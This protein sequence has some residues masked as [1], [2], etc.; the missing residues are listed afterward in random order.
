M[1]APS[2]VSQVQRARKSVSNLARSKVRFQDP[3]NGS[4]VFAIAL[5]LLGLS[6]AWAAFSRGGGDPGTWKWS[7]LGI[8]L[9]ASLVV[10]AGSLK[11]GA[12][13]TDAGLVLLGLL[14]GWMLFQLTPLPPAWVAVWSPRRWSTVAAAR[15]VTG[16]NMN[17]WLPLTTAPALTLQ[18]LLCVVPAMATFVAVREIGARPG[19]RMWI[20]V[21]P[22]VVIACLEATLG[23][24]QLPSAGADGNTAVRVSGTYPNPNHFAGLLEM[25]FPLMPLWAVATWKRAAGHRNFPERYGLQM[26][27]LALGAVCILAAVLV[28]LSRMAWIA[29]LASIA[30]MFVFLLAPRCNNETRMGRQWARWIA[31]VAVPLFIL[32]F[33]SPV[34]A[35]LRFAAPDQLAGDG[36][37]GIW[38]D[39][40]HLIAAYPWTG[41][42]IG[43]FKAG[44]F[45]FRTFAPAYTVDYA[46]N[47]YLQIVAELGWPGAALAGALA[48]WIFWCA[49]RAAISRRGHPNWELA[50]GILGA[51]IALGLH[52]L[53]DFNLYVPANALVLAWLAGIVVS[54]AVQESEA[55]VPARRAAQEHRE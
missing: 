23:F 14:L 47:D 30:G 43:A 25:A 16:Q 54:P 11:K 22:I 12:L 6:L 46:H 37:M 15:V 1:A 7:A 44:L 13:K 55:A 50:V 18:C 26:S 45:P 32:A 31:A 51:L 42:G 41:C 34:Q 48:V 27:V 8:S 53:T 20:Y 36:R 21:A 29:T 10:F 24:L 4:L 33:L 3:E 38:K 5:T 9:A 2:P 40:L 39:T 49:V 35:I 52:S 28:S 19:R 17:A